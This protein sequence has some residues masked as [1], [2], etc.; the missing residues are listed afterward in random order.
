MSDKNL[1]QQFS[2]V[3]CIDCGEHLEGGTSH[4][5]LSNEDVAGYRAIAAWAEASHKADNAARTQPFKL[6]DTEALRAHLKSS[7]HYF[8]PESVDNTDHEDLLAAHEDAHAEDD[9]NYAPHEREQHT[10]IGGRHK[11]I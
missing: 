5:H 7:G 8:H 3:Q 6:S 4:I 2:G 1:G 10:T 11:H 9:A